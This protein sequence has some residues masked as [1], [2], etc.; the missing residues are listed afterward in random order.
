MA[1][2][3]IEVRARAN[4]GGGLDVTAKT[5]AGK[6]VHSATVPDVGAARE[7][8]GISHGQMG[9]DVYVAAFGANYYLVD[10]LDESVD[11]DAK[12][13]P[14]DTTPVVGKRKKRSK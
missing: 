7:Q 12:S 11:E 2:T 9:H 13:S 4:A 8:F 14:R 3:R 6:L 5:E 10:C 1:A